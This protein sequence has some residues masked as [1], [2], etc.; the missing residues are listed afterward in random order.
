MAE[1]HETAFPVIIF[2][3]FAKEFVYFANFLTGNVMFEVKLIETVNNLTRFPSS[4]GVS[5]TEMFEK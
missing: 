5:V 3:S 1:K 4:S 2:Q